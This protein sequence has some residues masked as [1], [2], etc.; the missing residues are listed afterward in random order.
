MK[1]FP[2]I[3]KTEQ[4]NYPVTITYH[5]FPN[6]DEE[7]PESYIELNSDQYKEPEPDSF[8]STFLNK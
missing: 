4:G 1:Q 6:V 7:D 3:I 2:I 5:N 8:A